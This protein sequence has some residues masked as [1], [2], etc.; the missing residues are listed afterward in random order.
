[1]RRPEQGHAG[2]PSDDEIDDVGVR[3]IY[4]GLYMD[5]KPND[6]TKLVMDEYDWEP[7]RQP[8]ERT[9]RMFSNLDD[10]HE[11]GIHDWLKFC[12]LGYGRG[13]DHAS[14]D[15][16]A[17]KMTREE[18]IEMVRKYDAV[19]PRRDLDRWLEYVDMEEKEFDYICDTWRDPRVW[20]I[21]NGLWVKDDI[22]DGSSNYGP[23]HLPRETWDK[24]L[25]LE[26]RN[27]QV[28]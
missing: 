19:K 3:G 11:N 23:V 8:F 17:G 26:G 7:A 9:Y 18:A 25:G 24:Y 21:E 27:G 20:R 22:W 10:M 2:I 5:W 13:S 28:A 15:V 14:K 12:K 1:M 6:H 16:R 4:L